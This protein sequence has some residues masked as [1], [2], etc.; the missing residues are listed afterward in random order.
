MLKNVKHIFQMS[1]LVLCKYARHE[2]IDVLISDV[3]VDNSHMS[4]HSVNMTERTE[5]MRIL[6]LFYS[7]LLFTILKMHV[8][9]WNQILNAQKIFSPEGVKVAML[10]QVMQ[11]CKFNQKFSFICKY[12]R[13]TQALTGITPADIFRVCFITSIH[14]FQVNQRFRHVGKVDW[15]NTVFLLDELVHIERTKITIAKEDAT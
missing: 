10:V 3:P 15:T 6:R 5:E 9:Y 8:L 13:A 14:M 4:P 1:G 11:R 7:S 12:C 2:M